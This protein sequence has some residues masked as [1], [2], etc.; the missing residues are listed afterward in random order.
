LR[1]AEQ[2]PLTLRLLG[3][4]LVWI[5][6]CYCG[7]AARTGQRRGG[8]GTGVYPELAALGISE[9]SSPALAAQVGRLAAL[10]PSYE[11]TRQELAAQ[12][13]PLDVKVV[14]RIAGQLGAELLTTRYR[15]LQR[16]RAGDLPAG[17]EL[18]GKRVGAAVDGGRVRLRTVIVKQKG[19]GKGKK[20]RRRFRVEWREPKLLILF[21]M[22]RR[23]RMT[24][25]SRAWID[26]TFAGPDEAMELLAMHL[27]RLGAAAAAMVVFLA[28][29]APWVW[30]RLEWVE[31]RVGL[32]PRRTAR[33]LDWCHAAHHVSLAL[34]ALGL[35]GAERQRLYGQLRQ[36]LRGGRTDKV[37]AELTV[38]AWDHA[39]GSAAWVAIAYLEK[40]Q[41]AGHLDYA[42]FRRRGL[43]LGSGAIESAIRRVVN[44]RLKGNGLLWLEGN[45]EALLVMRAAV[46]TGRWQETLEHMRE[47]MGSD[48]RL[49]WQW[50]SPDMPAELKAGVLIA[51]PTPQPKAN[52]RS[53]AA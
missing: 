37:L 35:A 42:A 10:L 28:D 34:E 52:Q 17:R 2:R 50:E 25:K 22:D 33:V 38:R 14:H 9:G 40:H 45:A 24:H 23:G 44:L 43:P 31:K 41:L 11:M 7:P 8:E 6:T 16:F 36:W 47:V 19:K 32:R 20:R 18:A 48:R 3:G 12:G 4:L 15:D 13:K 21:E 30:D 49:D 53:T 29:G 27:H 1:S 46:L 39:E 26:G 51:P 5:S